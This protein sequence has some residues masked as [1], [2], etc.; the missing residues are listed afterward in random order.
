MMTTPITEDFLRG[1]PYSEPSDRGLRP[2]RLPAHVRSRDADAQLALMESH[3]SGVRIEFVTKSNRVGIELHTTRVAY[4][5][6]ERARGAVD[7]VVDGRFHS[8]TVLCEGD[9][10]ELDMATGTRSLLPGDA[11]IVYADDLPGGEKRVEFWLP[12]NE[13]IELIALHTDAEVRPLSR[14]ERAAEPVW[15][16]Y[17]SSISQGSN[18]AH[19]TG[20]WPAVAAR[21]AGVSLHNLGF[22][23]SAMV[24]PFM[25][26]LMRDTP[27]DLISV[28][29]GINVV[30]LDGMRRRIFV[31]AVHGFLDTI[32][33]GHPE[34]PVLVTSP[35]HCRIHEDT[36]GPGGVDPES[37]TEGA[38]RFIATGTKGDTELGRLTLQVV[39][40]AL[41]EVVDAR[42]DD[43]NL[44]FLD[45]LDLFGAEDEARLPLP[46]GLHPVTEAHRLIGDRFTDL[47]F[48]P[49]GA[50]GS[51]GGPSVQPAEH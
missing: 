28:K 1:T 41:A 49:N 40:E 37:I 18:A 50:F 30:N 34:T 48:G 45:G 32:R 3:P 10:I 23:G 25:A 19:P 39:R 36:P 21:R 11:D 22:G 15:L 2:H 43:P 46:D 17:G 26:R 27:A 31:P 24:D 35:T 29:L 4:R 8:S 6:M 44:H 13:Q 12:H 9:A 33:D 47:V 51:A 16:H 7:I 14:S 42:S 5:G 20:I 38:M